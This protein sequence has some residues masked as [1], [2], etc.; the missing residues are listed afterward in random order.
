MD[1]IVIKYIP[2]GSQ[3][4]LI[5]VQCPYCEETNRR[6]RPLGRPGTHTHGGGMEG[7]PA[8]YLGHR[9]AHCRNA[10]GRGYFIT[11]PQGLVPTTR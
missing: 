3:C 11:D 7:S 1:A 10:A 6:G 5:R 9:S 8:G 4:A 2:A